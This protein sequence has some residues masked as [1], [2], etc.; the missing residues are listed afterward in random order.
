MNYLWDSNILRAYT[1][2]HPLLLQNLARVPKTA[3]ALPIIVVVEQMRGRYEALLKA[4]SFNLLR[5]QQRLRATEMLLQE[6]AVCY[7]N[8]LAVNE[9]QV[10]QQR[11]KTKKR[12]ADIVIAAMARATGFTVVTRNLQDS[13]DL[14]PALKIQNWVDQAY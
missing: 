4:E 3:V 11:V 7:V 8:E 14:L 2:G 9:L 1:A 6:F 10:L 12:Y 5:E 13:K